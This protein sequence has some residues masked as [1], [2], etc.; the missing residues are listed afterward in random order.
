M[1]RWA[2]LGDQGEILALGITNGRFHRVC[3]D[4]ACNIYF[5]WLATGARYCELKVDSFSGLTKG[6]VNVASVP[7]GRIRRC[8]D[9]PRK[10]LR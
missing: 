6:E 4:F 7:H 8:K 3:L 1:K 10:G 5:H 2:A 9:V